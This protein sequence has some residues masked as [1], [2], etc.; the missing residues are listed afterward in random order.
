MNGEVI[1]RY[2]EDSHLVINA[3]DFGLSEEVNEGILR[4]HNEGFLTS[5]SLMANGLMFDQAVKMSHQTPSLGVGVHFNLVRGR[6]VGKSDSVRLFLDKNGYFLGK[7]GLVLK[8]LLKKP[9][10]LDQA[11]YECN[12]Q[13]ERIKEAGIIPTHIDSEKHIHMY[14]P[15]FERVA[16]VAVT[17]NIKWIRIVKE[18][19]SALKFKPT[20]AQIAKAWML[21]LFSY[22]CRNRARKVG[23]LSSDFFY[24]VL[25]AGHMVREVYAEIIEGLRPGITEVICHPG[26][27]SKTGAIDGFGRFFID[28]KRQVEL[29]SL[30]NE[31]LK[32]ELIR[33]NIKTV[34]YGDL[35]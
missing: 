28:S 26:V 10:V 23:L 11:E 8:R 32:D 35:G 9:L 18:N 29:D 6:P 20:I 3:D 15:L 2:S 19:G 12:A 27:R 30:L 16:K 13:V 5:A 24:G 21:G 14:P 1:K 25:H 17:H 4:A 33:L 31:E 7:V 34:N 22:R